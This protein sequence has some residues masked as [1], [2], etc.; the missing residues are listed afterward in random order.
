MEERAPFFSSFWQAVYL[1][2]YN[3]YWAYIIAM[4]AGTEYI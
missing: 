1:S 4:G 3:G 2:S